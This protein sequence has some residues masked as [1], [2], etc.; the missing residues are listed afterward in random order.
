MPLFVN[1]AL[2]NDHT[3]EPHLATE[4]TQSPV[5]ENI[6][7]IK[8][9]YVQIDKQNGY[10]YDRYSPIIF[11]VGIRGS[12]QD[13]ISGFLNM[14]SEVSC[15]DET[16]VISEVMTKFSASINAAKVIT[17]ILLLIQK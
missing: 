3:C 6:E 9:T 13:F 15:D 2:I 8:K 11:I 7:I 10:E 16:F 14:Q 17:C 1:I 5:N 12:G 4:Y